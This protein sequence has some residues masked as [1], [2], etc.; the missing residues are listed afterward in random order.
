RMLK[1]RL[2]HGRVL[3]RARLERRG[4][5]LPAALAGVLVAG[6][7]S[8]ATV[9]KALART[10][11][12]WTAAETTFSPRVLALVQACGHGI[13]ITRLRVA[14]AFLVVAGLVCGVGLT[15]GN[16]PLGA[17]LKPTAQVGE[18][19]AR[20]SNPKD[21]QLPAGAIARIG[22]MRWRHEGE[23]GSLAF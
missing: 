1:R 15:A 14:V 16:R 19:R 21:D 5:E 2:E 20:A 17:N 8:R 12:S 13:L 6:G 7:I 22:T 4:F 11:T 3:L 10:I 9:P 23:A 18:P